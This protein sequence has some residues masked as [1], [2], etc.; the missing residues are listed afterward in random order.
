MAILSFND[1]RRINFFTLWKVILKHPPHQK[2]TLARYIN[3]M[4]G[5]NGNN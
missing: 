4:E 5:H 3:P 1:S 2:N